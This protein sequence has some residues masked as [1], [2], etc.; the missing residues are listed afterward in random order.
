MTPIVKHGKHMSQINATPI[1]DDTTITI[2][3]RGNGMM[4]FQ[5]DQLIAW[6]TFPV[7]KIVRGIRSMYPKAKL[8]LI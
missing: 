2:Q 4:L 8:I 7:M 1:Y 3:Q 6:L 5:N